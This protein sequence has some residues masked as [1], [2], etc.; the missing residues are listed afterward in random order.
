MSPWRTGTATGVGSLPGTDPL[1]AAKLVLGELP[2]PHLPELP[3][4]G[5]L[6]DLAG[7]G[8]ALLAD[9]H[10]DVQP[11][12]WRFVPRSSRDGQR[13]RDLLRQDLDA[14][15]LAAHEAHPE[16]LKRQ[17]TGPW[18]LAT[19]VELHRGDKALADPA[20]VAD[21]VASLA[22]GLRQ[23]LAEVQRRFPSTTLHLQLDEP[24]LNGVLHAGIPT[25]SG[26]ATLRAPDPQTVRQHLRTCLSAHDSTVLH[27]CA[28]RPPVELLAEA[29]AI[30]VD[31]A[32]LDPRDDDALGEL[33]ERGTGLLLGVPRDVK[34][35][36]QT[37][38]RLRD[39]VGVRDVTL[40]PPCGLAF[41]RDAKSTLQQLT[42]AA[43]EL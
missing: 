12:G 4:R 41:D 6:A 34:A 33:L 10:V 27:C 7:R 23:H 35:A 26:F 16:H 11:S 25:A 22:G 14:L 5:H 28:R 36:V 18:T 40:T 42:K 29:T 32:M 39:R 43:G 38:G 13:A 3:N 1:E 31:A 2:I 20:A 8:A 24:S 9:L 19:V 17:A 37:V 15:E 30:S 21:I